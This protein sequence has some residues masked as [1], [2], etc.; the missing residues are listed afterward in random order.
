[1]SFIKRL[2]G[3]NAPPKPRVRICV[4]CGMPVAEHKDWCS[5]YRGQQ[6]MQLKAQQRAAATETS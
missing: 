6:E 1:M 2:F 3:K 4:E 5:I